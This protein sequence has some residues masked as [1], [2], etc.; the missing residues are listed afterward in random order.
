MRR[1][2]IG[3]CLRRIAVTAMLM[4]PSSAT[5]AAASLP[6]LNQQMVE[7]HGGGR[8]EE[9]VAIGEKALALAER[10]RGTEHPDTLTVVSNLGFLYQVQGRYQEA[11]LL[12]KRALA[13]YERTFGLEHADTLRSLNNL[14][15]LYDSQGRYGEAEPLYRR[16]LAGYEKAQGPGGPET[17][18][19]VNNLAFLLNEQGRYAE[20]ESLYQ[21]ALAGRERLNGP[22]HPETLIVVTNIASL[23]QA[24]GR[25]KAAEPLLKRALNGNEQALGPDHPD[26]LRSVNNLGLLFD[27][28]GRDGEAEPLYQRA[29]AGY[30]RA[31]GSE[32]PDTLISLN[33]LAMLYQSQQRYG[34]AEP[35]LKRTLAGVERSLGVGHPD[36]LQRMNNLAMLYQEQE[37]YAEAEP[38]LKRALD[39]MQRA[40]GP[41]HPSTLLQVNNLAGLYVDRGLYEEAE[42]L[43]HRALG[44][45]ERALGPEHPQTLDTVNNLGMLYLRQAAGDEDLLKARRDRA[46]QFL[47]RALAGYERVLGPAHPDTLNT[48]NNLAAV[49]FEQSKWAQAASFGRRSTAAI[50]AQT[51]RGAEAPLQR[52]T[53]K[54]QT[55]AERQNWEF[56]DLIKAAFRLAPDGK[57]PDAPLSREMFQTAQWATSSEAAR[58]LTQMAARGA[59]GDASLARLIRERQDLVEEWQTREKL[60]NAALG[61]EAAMR[62][63]KAEAENDERMGA[64]DLRIATIDKK[65]VAAFPDY[66]AFVNPEPL[67]VEEVQAQLGEDE[68]LVLFFDMPSRFPTGEETFIWVV[69]KNDMRWVRSSLVGT[70]SLTR[71]VQILRCGLDYTAWKGARCKELTGAPYAQADYF[72]GKPLPF[73]HDRAYWLYKAL[74]G[75]IEDMIKGKHL[76]I[77]PSGPL[78][79]LPFQVLVTAPSTKGDHKTTKWLARSNAVTVLPAVSSLKAL[80]ATSHPSRASKAMIGFGNPLLDGPDARYAKLARLAREKQSCPKQPWL[81]VAARLGLAHGT[82]GLE[83]RGALADV[84]LIRKQSPL[85]ETAD[86]I[87][88][89]ARDLGADASEMRLGARATEGDIKAI[90]A[91]G[92]LARYRVVHF[93]THGATA[94]ELNGTTEPGLI[95]TPPGKASD[96]DDGYLSASEIAALRLDADWVILSACNT[97]AGDAPSAEALS[98]LARAFIYAQARALLVSHWEVDSD[99]A[100]K[101]ITS[102]IREIARDNAVGRAEA[103]RRA[104]LALIDGGGNHRAAHPAYWAP[105]VVVGEGAR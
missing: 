33:N 10:E 65:L 32:H 31:L 25:Y 3:H 35:L 73:N 77:V 30:E 15:T 48:I 53:G 43:Y 14:G 20:A 87:C 27:Q 100:V 52:L 55:T 45:R 98:G 41:D 9:A 47:K 16:A 96:E 75:K 79:Q 1:A 23:Y 102:A 105:F 51:I 13:G 38:L 61:N 49:Y 57:T 84:G 5:I 85:P 104:M 50:A 29:L 6:D 19:S 71:E 39:G 67:T 26:T 89:V 42:P 95:L 78:T 86:E 8:Y 2:A 36:T 91:H 62:D 56:R 81:S 12:I 18:R 70:A 94:G 28:Q 99:A 103:L 37:R 97:A 64:I 92:E 74:F 80:R 17:L 76:L 63:A 60:R 68:V 59:S 82:A 101:L 4:L 72:A 44:G 11:E 88:A 21:R 93:A 46:E 54:K 58:S 7:L 66:A 24:Q 22:D 34:E 69:T 40:L 83:K 90:S